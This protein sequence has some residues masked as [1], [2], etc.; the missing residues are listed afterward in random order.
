MADR[1]VFAARRVPVPADSGAPIRTNRLLAGL[2]RRFAV[3]L[4]APQHRPGSPD[5]PADLE[6]A[7]TELPGVEIVTVPGLGSNKRLMQLAAVPRRRSWEFGRYTTPAL[8]RAIREAARGAA[9]VHYDDTG[10]GLTGPLPGVVNSFAPHNIEHRILEGAAA[11]DAGLRRAFARID[12]AKLRR[13]ES[14][15]WRSSDLCVAVSD[16]EA[17]IM[18]SAGAR[19]VLVCPNGTDPAERLP[20]PVLA[21]GEPLRLLF[22]GAGDY[23]PNRIGL[24]WFFDEV[25]PLLEGRQPWTL[26]IVG[27]PPVGLPAREGVVVHGL[28][29]SVAP[30]YGRAH[31]A[32]VPVPYGSG[33]RLKVVEAMA[34]GVVV[35][36]TPIG[37][38]GLGVEAGRHY[39]GADDPAGF[40]GAVEEAAARLRGEQGG[41]EPML[42]A[43]RAAAEPLFWPRI[44][45]RL[46]DAY[47]EA[48]AA[49]RARRG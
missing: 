34:R 28:V 25:A 42:A 17:E 48:I 2:A 30:S 39:L 40:A 18:R 15:L 49:R 29:E 32:V 23:R 22:V 5:G 24:E 8:R 41:A 44:A 35:V 16:S 43:A 9:L 14:G 19:S 37:A 45:E 11:A 1:I 13:E 36:S 33:T 31:A 27:R 46:A 26:D 3:T 21:P 4:V 6:R 7:R 38:E 12:A 47:A 20:L 10:A